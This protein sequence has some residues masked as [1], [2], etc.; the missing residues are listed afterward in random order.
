MAASPFRRRNAAKTV[1]NLAIAEA[2]LALA[3]DRANAAAGRR[4]GR[5]RGKLLLLGGALCRSGTGIGVAVL[6]TGPR[7]S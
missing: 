4:S 5:S 1:R 7:T 6:A 3:K 2:A